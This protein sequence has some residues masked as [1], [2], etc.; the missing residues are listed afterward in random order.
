MPKDYE[1]PLPGA[2]AALARTQGL[3]DNA[4]ASAPLRYG[5]AA[6]PT[7]PP[8]VLSTKQPGVSSAL[9]AVTSNVALRRSLSGGR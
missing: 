9:G 2:K 5:R 7:T 3:A 4:A 6:K 8:R 1:D